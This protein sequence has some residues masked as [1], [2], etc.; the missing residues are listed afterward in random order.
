MRSNLLFGAFIRSPHLDVE[1]KTGEDE[2]G[3]CQSVHPVEKVDIF[4]NGQVGEGVCLQKQHFINQTGKLGRRSSKKHRKI[5][6]LP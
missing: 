2:V 1:E 5:A 4:H 3:K 6:K